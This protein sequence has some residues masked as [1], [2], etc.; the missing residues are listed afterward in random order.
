LHP[1]V[2]VTH[3]F[4]EGTA[5][6]LRNNEADVLAALV[7]AGT[8]YLPDWG[9]IVGE[10]VVAFLPAQRIDRLVQFVESLAE[11]LAHTEGQ[12]ARV[13]HRLREPEAL[14]VVEEGL[15]QSARAA[16]PDRI[17]RIARLV[18][19][20]LSAERLNLDQTLKLLRIHEGLTESELLLLAYYSEHD[21][22]RT[23]GT[24]RIAREHPTLF[25]ELD[26]VGEDRERVAAN[27]MRRTYLQSLEKDRLLARGAQAYSTTY[28]GRML[29]GTDGKLWDRQ[30]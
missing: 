12:L 22:E 23:E 30:G 2:D 26:E 17:Q 16:P 8:A 11:R 21:P 25:I 5:I 13:M 29:L 4:T 1:A 14:Y 24:L 9:G 3:R 15:H 18:A 19:D 7:R 27:A 6:S 20:G 10:L 28:A